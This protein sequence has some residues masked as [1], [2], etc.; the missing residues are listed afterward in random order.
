MAYIDFLSANHKSTVRDYLGRVNDPDFPKAKAA[1]LAKKFDFDYWDGDR[2]INYGGYRY[3]EGRWEN[4]QRTGPFLF[5]FPNGEQYEGLFEGGRR[6][7]DWARV[8]RPDPP[9]PRRR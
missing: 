1:D 4:G 3:M 7:G 6:V 8:A 2:R 9:A 5:T